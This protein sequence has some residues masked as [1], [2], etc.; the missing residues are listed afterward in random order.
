MS[1]GAGLSETFQ[2]VDLFEEMG[3]V[4]WGAEQR[5]RN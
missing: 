3:F 5:G 2:I 1:V 4:S